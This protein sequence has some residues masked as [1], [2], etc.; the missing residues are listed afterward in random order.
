[1]VS[2]VE[3]LQV[4]KKTSKKSNLIQSD[5]KNLKS[6]LYTLEGDLRNIY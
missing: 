4:V 1:M 5:L 6:K 3:M 2:D